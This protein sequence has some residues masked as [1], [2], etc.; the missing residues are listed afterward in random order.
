MFVCLASFINILFARFIRV[1]AYSCEAFILILVEYSVAVN[2]SL[3]S[4]SVVHGQGHL[5]GFQFKAVKNRAAVNILLH[6]HIIYTYMH[7]YKRTYIALLGRC[8]GLQLLDHMWCV[9]EH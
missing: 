8:L 4:W 7:I 9:I 6:M 2:N 3:F 1:V 5:G